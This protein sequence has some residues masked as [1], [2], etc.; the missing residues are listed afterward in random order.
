[1]IKNT[2]TAVVTAALLAGTA[3]ASIG[4]AQAD[5]RD[6]AMMAAGMATVAAGTASA[7]A[8]GGYGYRPRPTYYRARP[9]ADCCYERVRWQRVPAYAPY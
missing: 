2:L 4:S 9:V 5:W 8:G 3:A 1:M 6:D 7:L